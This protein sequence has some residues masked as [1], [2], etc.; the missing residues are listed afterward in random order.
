MKKEIRINNSY[1]F[2]SIQ[3]LLKDLLNIIDVKILQIIS[4]DFTP[5]ELNL[6]L[7]K[8]NI[9]DGVEHWQ[10]KNSFKLDAIKDMYYVHGIFILNKDCLS[11]IVSHEKPLKFVTSD[12]KFL[13]LSTIK[14]NEWHDLRKD[15]NDLPKDD[16]YVIVTDGKLWTSAYYDK[17]WMVHT[18]VG[19]HK[20]IKW[21]EVIIEEN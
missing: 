10:I 8:N 20:I 17:T 12:A 21:K 1:T 19:L 9:L 18:I 15:P 16:K 14:A 11:V 2:K 4:D 3:I 6:Y 13:K 7:Y 5:F